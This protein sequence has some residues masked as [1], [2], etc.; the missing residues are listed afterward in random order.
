MKVK[1]KIKDNAVEVKLIAKHPMASGQ[2]K[3]KEGKIIPAHYIEQL[4][5]TV[6]DEII[7]TANLGPAVSKNPYLKFYYQG[8]SG[9]EIILHWKDN[10][11][12][13]VSTKATVK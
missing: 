11:G 9:D 1:A 2:V 7:F 10:K 4:T 8:S 12:E 3:D 5:A 6:D 13:E